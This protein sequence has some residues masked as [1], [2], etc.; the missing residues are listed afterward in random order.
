MSAG[1]VPIKAKAVQIW[2]SAHM[3]ALAGVR[4][5]RWP[6]VAAGHGPGQWSGTT[7]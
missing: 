7:T 3:R 5:P 2:D 4:M 6:P 1:L